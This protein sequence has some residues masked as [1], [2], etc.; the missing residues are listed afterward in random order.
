MNILNRKS[1]RPKVFQCVLFSNRCSQMNES[2]FEDRSKFLSLQF[3]PHQQA[4]SVPALNATAASAL[5][6]YAKHI[7][8]SPAFGPSPLCLSPVTLFPPPPPEH[9]PA[10]GVRLG[11]GE[12]LPAPYQVTPLLQSQHNYI[13]TKILTR[14]SSGHGLY[15]K[16]IHKPKKKTKN[17][18]PTQFS[19]GPMKYS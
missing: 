10:P 18:K 15:S 13:T 2:I 3:L 5:Y 8:K 9:L 6:K 16:E 7:H 14:L 19:T 4:P 17:K 11:G 1:Q 12:P